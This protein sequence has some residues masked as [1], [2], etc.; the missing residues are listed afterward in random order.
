MSGFP[1]DMPE[2]GFTT[3]QGHQYPD[4]EA[5]QS[6]S[7]IWPT[8]A[9]L[10]AQGTGD[11]G[12]DNARAE[13][14]AMSTEQRRQRREQVEGADDILDMDLGDESDDS[15]P[16]YL[17][18]GRGIR[19]MQDDV[20]QARHLESDSDESDDGP[21]SRKTKGK[22]RSA[23]GG[24][25]RKAGI[26]GPRK[27]AEPTGDIKLRL[28]QANQAFLN[29]RCEEAR[30]IA[31]EIIRINAETYEAW[32][33]LSACFKELGEYN[34]AVK[35]LMI[36]ATWR[37]KHPGPWYA[38]LYFA[39]NET[40]DLRSE[41]LISAQYAAQ[42]ILRANSQDLEARRI[43]A[44]IMLERR[45]LN[46]AAREYE[47]ILKRAPLDTEVVQTLA[48]IYVDLGQIE[49]AMKLYIKTINKFKKADVETDTVLVTDAYA[50]VELFGLLEK[51]KDGIKELRSVARWLVGR[52][53]ED[54]WDQFIDDDREWDD[55]DIRRSECPQFDAKTY[56]VDTYGPGLPVELR[57]KL[58]LYRLSLGHYM[59]ALR[60]FNYLKTSDYNGQGLI[61]EFPHLFEEVGDNLARKGYNKDALDYYLPLAPG[62]G[63]EGASLQLKM[64]NCWLA[65]KADQEAELC[66]QNAVQME[67]DNIPARMEL[68][69]LYERLNEKEQSFMY[70]NE[71]IAIRRTQR[72]VEDPESVPK[73][74]DAAA[75]KKP[76]RKQTSFASIRR[77]QSRYVPRRLLHPAERLK[78]EAARAEHLQSQYSI[79]KIELERMRAGDETATLKWMEAAEDLIDD[80]RGFKTFYPWDKYVKFLGYSNDDKFQAET[81]L[82]TDL[83]EMA[84]RLSK[85][86]GAD[87]EDK[88]SA[89][90][91]S[92]PADYRGISFSSWLDIFLE[93]AIC[94]AKDGN[95][96]ESYE[97]CE[98][99]RDAIVFYHKRED[100][101]LIHVCW[102]T[103]ALLCND[104]EMCI[105]VARYFMREYQFT[106]DSYRMYAAIARLCQSPVSWYCSGPEQK[107]MLRQVKAMDFNLVDKSRRQ[108]GYAEKAGYTS[109]DKNG[110]PIL[111]DDMDVALL[112]LYGHILYSGTSYAYS[113]NYFLRA[114][115]LDPNNAII[116]LNIGLAY[117]HH[118]LKRQADNRQFMIL[119]GLTFL[120]DYYNSRKQSAAVEERQE[121][122]YNLARVYHMLGVSHLAIK[123]YLRV[124]NETKDHESTREDIT[125]DTAHNLKIL[126][127]ITVKYVDHE[128]SNRVEGTIIVAAVTLL[129]LD[130]QSGLSGFLESTKT[131]GESKPLT[132]ISANPAT[133]NKLKNSY[134]L[135]AES[136]ESAE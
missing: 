74:L 115:A 124:L 1:D 32:T 60:H 37:P 5:S 2:Y 93:Y 119:Q 122:H 33:L 113:L 11:V 21:M 31:S 69:R 59:E 117:V 3:G 44:S 92:I 27:A 123:Y 16:D 94:L 40:G 112:M 91:A 84:D 4:P 9:P 106:T 64:G 41:F 70:V 54:F 107:Y 121:A 63:A 128:N 101:F 10:T 55:D 76:R 42:Q 114:Y 72:Q 90:S 13:F 116:N 125:I 134:K 15:D 127:M 126:C 104:E 77:P 75:S 23:R 25:G 98:S 35:A 102:G 19:K 89:T 67:E 47:I 22:R 46:H 81:K 99:A 8:N 49:V 73:S 58:G 100:M 18:F 135:V 79:M 61:E 87:A 17:E 50:Y 129:E 53:G 66:F 12:L 86:L 136:L 68:A 65:E 80:F 26:R 51:Y 30:D 120:F 6:Q 56:P 96:R 34:S 36:A 45:N 20:R 132:K 62:A 57:I 52:K 108:K 82:E 118:S 29:G 105:R 39:L 131:A 109:Q 133:G 103:C 130:A 83:T 24:K 111:N 7:L 28:G 48:S 14:A 110:K 38:A 97:I 71:I 85:K 78:E 43:K 95:D 88:T